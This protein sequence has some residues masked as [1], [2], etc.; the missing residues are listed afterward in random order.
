MDKSEEGDKKGLGWISGD[1]RRFVSRY[2]KNGKALKVPHMG[3][4]SISDQNNKYL[5]NYMDEDRRYYFVHS[6]HLCPESDENILCTSEYGGSFV[7]GVCKD[8]I[9]GVQFHPEKS[10]QYGIQFLKNYFEA[11]GRY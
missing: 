10:H 3:W 5:F 6:Y 2:D 1:V 8:N 9:L 11:I 4:S 7:S